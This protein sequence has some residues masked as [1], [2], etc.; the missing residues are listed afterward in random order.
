MGG[1]SR[2]WQGLESAGRTGPGWEASLPKGALTWQELGPVGVGLS[3]PGWVRELAAWQLDPQ[4]GVR[5]ITLAVPD[6][7]VVPCPWHRYFTGH[8]GPCPW[9]T[10]FQHP[11]RA[12]SW[13]RAELAEAGNSLRGW[14]GAVGF[15]FFFS[16]I[17]KISKY[18]VKPKASYIFKL[19]SFK[20]RPSKVFSC[21]RLRCW[22]QRWGQKSLFDKLLFDG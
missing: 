5:G 19:K 22:G 13:P 14:G 18:E 3:P 20:I 17:M 11:I 8:S 6:P 7:G 15:V 21:E 2:H 10:G 16:L 9:F 4:S 12:L 1:F